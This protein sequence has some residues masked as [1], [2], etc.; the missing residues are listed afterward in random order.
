MQF[1]PFAFPD[2]ITV[3][4]LFPTLVTHHP[5][6]LHV[7]AVRRPLA[8]LSLPLLPPSRYMSDSVPPFT[9]L[10]PTALHPLPTS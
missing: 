4:P 9:L 6:D 8:L 10:P 2:L 7:T 1:D 5:P 3:H